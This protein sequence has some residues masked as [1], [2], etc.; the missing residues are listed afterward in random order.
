[1]S[2]HSPD[3]SERGTPAPSETDEPAA[4]AGSRLV[5]ALHAV[6]TR[7]AS[8]V[9]NSAL[10]QWLTAEPDPEVIVID[11]RETWTVGPF[12]RVLDWVVDRLIDA[13]E[14]SR[15]VAL[16]RRGV[17][18]TRAAPLR[19]AGLLAVM[20]GLVVAGSG[21]LGGVSTTQLAVGVGLAVGGLI[22]MQD[23]RDWATL[24]ETR[25]VA[26][27]IAALEP[28]EPPETAAGDE[29]DPREDATPSSSS[30][31]SQT[32]EDDTADSQPTQTE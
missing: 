13:A 28:P 14:D 18:A 11:L 21:L 6:S 30:E 2:T 20:I 17:T 23:D 8:W 10:Y 32:N 15:V 4:L 9:R 25:P 5:S 22:A 1:M 19:V 3:E 31:S 16:A 7:G 24:R 12:L 27:T 26:L 29:T